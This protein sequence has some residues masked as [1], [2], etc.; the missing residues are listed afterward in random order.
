M[1]S[2]GP[3]LSMQ[4]NLGDSFSKVNRP[5]CRNPDGTPRGLRWLKGCV[6]FSSKRTITADF[7]TLLKNHQKKLQTDYFATAS[8]LLCFFF[9]FFRDN[10]V[11]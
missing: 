7:K 5:P 8:T 2:C 3:V 4:L 1:T 6:G 9:A 11:R 10:V